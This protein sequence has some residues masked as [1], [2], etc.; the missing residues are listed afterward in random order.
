MRLFHVPG[1]ADDAGAA[2]R[3]AVAGG[4]FALQYGVNNLEALGRGGNQ[5]ALQRAVVDYMGGQADLAATQQSKADQI[6]DQPILP[7]MTSIP[8]G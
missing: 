5:I 7:A 4:G 8:V 2:P 6:D 1:R 3:L